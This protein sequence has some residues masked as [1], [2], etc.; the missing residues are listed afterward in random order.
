MCGQRHRYKNCY[1]IAPSKRTQGWKGKQEIFDE[2]NKKIDLP[3]NRSGKHLKNWF[4][5]TFNYD[6]FARPPVLT[7]ENISKEPTVK[8][9]LGVFIVCLLFEVASFQE[10]KLYHSWTLDGASD[11]YVCNDPTISD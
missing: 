9:S 10:Y 2:I 1:Y 8:E 11:T 4:L 6:G 7:R 3:R 5:K